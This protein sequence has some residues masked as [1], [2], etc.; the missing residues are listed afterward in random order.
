M[1]T[2]IPLL[3]SEISGNFDAG[4]SSQILSIRYDPTY[5]SP[6]IPGQYP[7]DTALGSEDLYSVKPLIIYDYKL[8]VVT[9]VITQLFQ[10]Y[11]DDD[12]ITRADNWS[13]T[14]AEFAMH[15]KRHKLGAG[16]ITDNE[17]AIGPFRT[18]TLWYRAKK[19]YGKTKKHTEYLRAKYGKW[20]F[21]PIVLS[22]NKK[23]CFGLS[24]ANVSNFHLN[25][26]FYAMVT[27]NRWHELD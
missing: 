16:N 24:I 12:D 26:S 20:V 13:T 18:T 22:K 19:R 4:E 9:D 15:L 17:T 1:G 23:N 10:F 5:D 21:P 2:R 27:I 25:R 3:R 8:E 14:S 6:N 11:C 7:P